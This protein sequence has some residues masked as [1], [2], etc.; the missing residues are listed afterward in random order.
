MEFVSPSWCE[1]NKKG[2]GGIYREVE[3]TKGDEKII[4]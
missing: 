3:G 1:E 4:K 2:E